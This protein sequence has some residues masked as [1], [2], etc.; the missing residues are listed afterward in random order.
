MNNSEEGLYQGIKSLLDNPDKL[1]QYKDMAI[2][3]GN[4]FGVV[5]AQKNIEQLLESVSN[6]N[7][8]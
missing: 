1:I 8:K 5:N 3:R 2:S 6:L 4:M 7:T